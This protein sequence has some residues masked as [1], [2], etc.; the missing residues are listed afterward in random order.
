M[1]KSPK[2][3]GKLKVREMMNSEMLNG[4]IEEQDGRNIKVPIK[5]ILDECIAFNECSYPIETTFL[6]RRF[7]ISGLNLGYYTPEDLPVIVNRFCSKIRCI[8]YDYNIG[9]DNSVKHYSIKNGTLYLSEEL[10]SINPYLF[11]I[12]AFAAF[13]EVI[14]EADVYHEHEIFKT[15]LSYM[16]GE[17][18]LNMDKNDSRIIMP[19]TEELVCGQY[20]YELRA[21]YTFFNLPIVLV[22][23]LFIALHKNENILIRNSLLGNFTKDTVDELVNDNKQVSMLISVVDV[24]T[25]SYI[26]QEYEEA[27]KLLFK[28]QKIINLLFKKVDQDYL[29]FCALILTDEW[30]SS[31]MKAMEERLN[32]Q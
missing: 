3:K 31:L 14:S 30:R 27:N 23:Q 20:K 1:R 17:K 19:K 11:E 12:S 4:L 21:G 24:I 6:I 8:K 2:E 5:D 26:N 13:F 15:V 22:K 16:A 18:F 29:A 32:S 10:E 7:S 9:T 25:R 28:Y